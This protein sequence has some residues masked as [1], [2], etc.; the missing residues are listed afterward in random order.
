MEE[1]TDENPIF[2]LLDL[3]PNGIIVIRSD[4]SICFWNA[5]MVEWTDIP[6]DEAKGTNLIERY[7]ALKNPIIYS[8]ISQIFEGGPAVLFSSTFHPHLIPCEFPNGGLRVEK[9]SCIPFYQSTGKYALVLIEDMSDLTNQIKAYRTMKAVAEDQRD[10]LQKAQDAIYLANKALRETTEYLNNL[11]DY[12]NAPII[13]WDSG[14]HITRFNHAFEHLTG[15]NQEE[16][17]G[18]TLD[19]LF[20]DETRNA[21]MRLIRK[22]IEGERWEVVEIPILVKN[23][24]VRTVLWNSANILDPEGRILSTIAQGVDITDRKYAEQELKESEERFRISIEKAPEAILLFD[25]NQNR[26]IEANSRAEQIFGCSRQQLLDSGPQQFYKP[27]QPDERSITETVNEHRLRVQA[28]ETVV[29]ERNICNNRGEDLVMEV[30]LVQLQSADR[31]LIR[32]SFIDITERKLLEQEMVYHE[33]ELRQFSAALETSNKK[34]TLLSGIT[35]HDINNQLTVLM[36]FLE[37]LEMMQPDTSF[38]DYFNKITNAAERIQAMIQFTKTYEGIGVNA[39]VWQNTRTLVDSAA[40]DVAMGDIRLVNDMPGDFTIFADQL[41][42]KVFFNL[43]DNAVRYGGNI[44][45]IRF[46]VEKPDG[47][48]FIV[49]SDDGAGVSISEKEKI[50]ERGFGKNTGLGLFLSR[51]ILAITGI[52]I[53]ETGDPGKGARFEMTVPK[54]MH[55]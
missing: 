4:Y 41:I 52:T 43:M 40:K 24:S 42:V 51:E 31:R 20:P 33:Q 27:D 7:P 49:C 23:G 38:R 29:F 54:G 1:I 14:F 3:I 16:M 22:A 12:A 34:L 6:A 45:T 21:S 32:S 44:T 35:R 2:R 13:T 26:Y 11:F 19:L 8:R 55:R 53:K 46:S 30:R 36:G 15:R 25:I 5:C 50:F 47:D 37:I 10:D 18:K 39:P 17:L 9:I 48:C 28:G